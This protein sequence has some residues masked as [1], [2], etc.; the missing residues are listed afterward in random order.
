[1]RFTLGE[2]FIYKE[3]RRN[4]EVVKEKTSTWEIP[5][6]TIFLY[7]PPRQMFGKEFDP[8]LE[9]YNPPKMRKLS[10]RN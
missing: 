6:D 3:E 4:R 9:I 5:S 1:M 7:P 2:T 8:G 10:I